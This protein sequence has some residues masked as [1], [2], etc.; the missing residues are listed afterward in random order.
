MA[1]LAVLDAAVAAVPVL[2]DDPFQVLE[3]QRDQRHAPDQDLS[4]A[5]VDRVPATM[6]ECN[7]PDG[8]FSPL[9]VL[10]QVFVGRQGQELDEFVTER[11]LLEEAT[12]LLVAVAE[13]ADLLVDRAL[14][15]RTL[16]I[17]V[18]EPLPDL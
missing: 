18:A 17:A 3:L 1:A 4:V 14:D 10:G 16:D 7:G 9:P 6:A 5:H 12:R 13:L 15:V 8:G 2:P 11:H